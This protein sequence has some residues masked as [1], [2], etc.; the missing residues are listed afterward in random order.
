MASRLP[1]LVAAGSEISGGPAATA[2]VE[3]LVAAHRV[4]EHQHSTCL[5]KTTA[6]AGSRC[7]PPPRP[8]G[9]GRRPR[10]RGHKARRV[11]CMRYH[12]P[13]QLL[14]GCRRHRPMRRRRSAAPSGRAT[15]RDRC[16]A[17]AGS[18][19]RAHRRWRRRCGGGPSVAY[20][21]TTTTRGLSPVKGAHFLCERLGRADDTTHDR[22]LGR[23]APSHAHGRIVHESRCR[24]TATTTYT[25]TTTTITTT[26]TAGAHGA[27][28][29]LRGDR[30]HHRRRRR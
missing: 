15:E 12:I 2:A 22:S 14:P 8:E 11:C 13:Q 6:I 20:S 27:S 25:T 17:F 3:R 26:P 7:P 29:S 16:G 19:S 4:V 1:P 21:P 9:P 23:P 30:R 24:L 18:R 5:G 28:G 10:A